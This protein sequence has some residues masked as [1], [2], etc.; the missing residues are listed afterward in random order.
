MWA[1]SLQQS[2]PELITMWFYFAVQR[3]LPNV[4]IIQET[5]IHQLCFKG[6]VM[7]IA[8]TDMRCDADYGYG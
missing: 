8:G 5:I 2:Y 3:E 4:R 7:L 6:A 1:T